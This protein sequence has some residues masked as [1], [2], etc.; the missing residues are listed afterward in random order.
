MK[1]IIKGA[2]VIAMAISGAFVALAPAAAA[3]EIDVT[4]G[5]VEPLPIAITDFQSAD[6]NFVGGVARYRPGAGGRLGPRRCRAAPARQPARC[7]DSGCAPPPFQSARF[8]GGG[9]HRP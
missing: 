1:M 7:I 6:G 2:L 8:T 9:D 3:V 5:N 4:Q